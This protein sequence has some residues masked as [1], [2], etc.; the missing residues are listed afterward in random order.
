MAVAATVAGEPQ[1]ARF[2]AGL[3]GALQVLAE[4]SPR[5]PRA[6]APSAQ[7]Q[8]AVSAA[9]EELPGL[10]FCI[11]MK[12]TILNSLASMAILEQNVW[13]L[14]HDHLRSCWLSQPCIRFNSPTLKAATSA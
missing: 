13:D 4:T 9:F 5:Q 11:L 10:F 12:S 6:T 3:P 7:L 2:W 14:M 8:A 1:E